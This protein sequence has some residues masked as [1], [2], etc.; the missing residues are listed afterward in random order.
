MTLSSSPM[1]QVIAWTFIIAV[2]LWMV[3][4]LHRL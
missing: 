4:M 2:L 3:V 1:L